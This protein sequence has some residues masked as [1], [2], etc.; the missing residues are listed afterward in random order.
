MI[1]HVGILTP[2]D[3]DCAVAVLLLAAVWQNNKQNWNTPTFFFLQNLNKQS[4]IQEKKQRP[5]EKMQYFECKKQICQSA[6]MKKY[7]V[8]QM[9]KGLETAS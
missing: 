1:L 5:W 3:L 8:P 4:C 9:A 2:M 6:W 7:H